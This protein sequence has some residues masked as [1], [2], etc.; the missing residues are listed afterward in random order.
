MLTI[1][2]VTAKALARRTRSAR[3]S[4]CSGTHK[5]PKFLDITIESEEERI[6]GET[7]NG[8]L[9]SKGLAAKEISNTSSKSDPRSE[10]HP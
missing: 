7:D 4:A 1:V 3:A 8:E 5:A 9:A 2:F 10:E 6:A